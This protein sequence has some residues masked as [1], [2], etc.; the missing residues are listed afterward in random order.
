[1]STLKT[2]PNLEA[3][4][5]CA[6]FR[7]VTASFRSK[8]ENFPRSKFLFS[9]HFPGANSSPRKLRRRAFPSWW[10]VMCAGMTHVITCALHGNDFSFRGFLAVLRGKTWCWSA[11]SIVRFCRNTKVLEE[12]QWWFSPF[13]FIATTTSDTTTFGFWCALCPVSALVYDQISSYHTF[14]SLDHSKVIHHAR[15]QHRGTRNCG[16]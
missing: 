14:F 13:S 3:K 8:C 9:R 16:R 5:E 2:I 4:S 11:L 12:P 6:S 10:A 15:R 1:M 7:L